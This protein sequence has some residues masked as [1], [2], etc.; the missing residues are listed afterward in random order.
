MNYELFQKGPAVYIPFL[1]V[2]LVVTIMAYGAFPYLFARLRKTSITRKK[3]VLLCYGLNF[4]VL[5]IFII[6]NGGASN[7]AP[8]LLWTS[9]FSGNGVKYLTRNGLLLKTDNRSKDAPGARKADTKSI[10]TNDTKQTTE[11]N[12]YKITTRRSAEL[13]QAISKENAWIR[14][15]STILSIIAAVSIVGAMITQSNSISYAEGWNPTAAYC[16]FLILLVVFILIETRIIPNCTFVLSTMASVVLACFAAIAMF[17]YFAFSTQRYG[18]Y[19][20]H[21]LHISSNLANVF[22]VVF[23]SAIVLVLLIHLAFWMWK[24]FDFLRN[25]Y[26][27]TLG[28]K[29]RQYR[30]VA[31]M[32]DYYDK[33][34]IT[35]EEYERNKQ[36]ILKKLN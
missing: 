35:K 17:G 32:K 10:T 4:A 29:E 27:A 31:R 1:L 18:S 5:A 16:V 6:F 34:I 8:Y 25:K 36:E 26:H 21:F 7:G 15:L 3:Y 28:Y 9:I 30:Q 12:T 19:N 24:L 20:Y 13:K 33:G 23:I 22:N 2:S 14:N 11:D